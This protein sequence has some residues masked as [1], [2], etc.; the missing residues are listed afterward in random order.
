MVGQFLFATKAFLP[1]RGLAED[2]LGHRITKASG[3]EAFNDLVSKQLI[4]LG[5]P[6]VRL[7]LWGN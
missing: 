1:S 3:E 2:D 4:I 7:P 5:G 6:G